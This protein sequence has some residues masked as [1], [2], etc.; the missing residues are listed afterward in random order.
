MYYEGAAYRM[1]NVVIGIAVAARECSAG[2]VSICGARSGA[3]CLCTVLPY[4][5]GL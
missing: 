3:M 1:A 5:L 2:L 4:R